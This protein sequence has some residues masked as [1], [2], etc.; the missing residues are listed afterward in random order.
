ML[1]E[2][3]TQAARFGKQLIFQVLPGAAHPVVEETGS[4]HGSSG[5]EEAR[6]AR[7]SPWGGWGG[8]FW[9]GSLWG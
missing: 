4:A 6:A 7:D 2:P 5:A 3:F 1:P 8:D 9:R